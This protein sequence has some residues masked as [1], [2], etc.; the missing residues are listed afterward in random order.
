MVYKLR[1]NYTSTSTLE[2]FDAE[3]FRA[4]FALLVNVPVERV[5][6]RAY[7]A[8][9]IIEAE[10]EYDDEAAANT[11]AQALNQMTPAEQSQA[12]GV[13][14]EVN[15]A[16]V[17][18]AE[19]LTEDPTSASSMGLYAAVG[20]VVVLLIVGIYCWRKKKAKG[21]GAR[22]TGGK[23]NKNQYGSA[24]MGGPKPPPGPM[25]GDSSFLM[26]EEKL[27]SFITGAVP[28]SPKPPKGPAP[29]ARRRPAPP[30]AA[31]GGPKK[32][33]KPKP[34]KKP[35]AR[36]PSAPPPPSISTTSKSVVEIELD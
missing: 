32:P 36:P 5:T 10:A 19:A 11:Q 13:P 1:A 34:P 4:S 17:V 29:R 31:S 33:T 8:S 7:A 26:D 2:E 24:E 28:A 27:D 16:P 30:P 9:I 21:G 18:T 14:V 35:P 25:H 15:A 22:A 12:L 20:V 3:G 23:K 6:V